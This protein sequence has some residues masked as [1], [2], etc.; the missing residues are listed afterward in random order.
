M[1]K[2]DPPSFSFDMVFNKCISNAQQRIKTNLQQFIPVLSGL[3]IEYR[4]SAENQMLH[5]ILPCNLQDTIE[6]RL[7]IN[8]YDKR[9]VQ[10]MGR[11][12]YNDIIISST[13]CPFCTIGEVHTV[14]HF[15]PKADYPRLSVLPINLIPACSY[16]NSQKGGAINLFFH[17]YFDIFDKTEL[18]VVEVIENTIPQLKFSIGTCNGDTGL[19]SKI[20]GIDTKLK[21]CD[22]FAVAATLE[23]ITV[24]STLKSMMDL[25]G[26]PLTPKLV[27][28]HLQN[29]EK[30]SKNDQR[31][32]L[33]FV[34]GALSNSDWY[35]DKGWSF[36]ECL[37]IA[38]S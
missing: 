12:Y 23:L 29:L 9:L 10:G 21:L 31:V 5:Q 25:I 22:R 33:S 18:L 16:C 37:D 35:C 13:I 14:D 36:G 4:H 24:K 7:L 1:L 19:E 3:E 30:D 17:P 8:V 2:L 34:Y 20:R 27:K 32:Y 6:Q 26:C 38:Y 28:K 11:D 15:L